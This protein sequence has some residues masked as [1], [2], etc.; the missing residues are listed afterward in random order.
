MPSISKLFIPLCTIYKSVPVLFLLVYQKQW[1]YLI[2][3]KSTD[4]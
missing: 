3:F 2:G 4:V 1:I